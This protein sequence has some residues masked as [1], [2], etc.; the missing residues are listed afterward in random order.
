MTT[1]VQFKL[2]FNFIDSTMSED[3]KHKLYH[4]AA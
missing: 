4:A 3:D 2:D 1:I